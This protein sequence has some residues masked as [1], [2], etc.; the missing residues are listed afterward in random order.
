[1]AVYL[2]AKCYVCIKYVLEIKPSILHGL[3]NGST[4]EIYPV[5]LG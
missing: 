1:M 4:L 3:S 2:F 5:P